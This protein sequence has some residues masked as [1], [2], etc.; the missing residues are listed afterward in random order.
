MNIKIGNLVSI[1]NHPYGLGSENVKISAIASM[2]PPI[3]V[4]S[5]MMNSVKEFD[6]ETGEEKPKQVKCIFYSHKS[7]KFESYWFNVN[8]LKL[9]EELILDDLREERNDIN[10]RG[11]FNTS[12]EVNLSSVGI[13]YPKSTILNELKRSFLN[14]QVVLKSCDHELGK[15]KTTFSKVDNK[16]SQKNNSHLDF[17]PP[18][19]TV[20]DVLLN[21]EKVSYNT[22]SGNQRKI[23]SYFL[24]KCKW[25]N[26]L[27][28]HFSE[29]FLPIDTVKLVPIAKSLKFV[30]EIISAKSFIRQNFSGHIVLESGIIIEHTYIQPI[31]LIFNH[32][33]YKVKYYDFFKNKFSEI[34]L[35]EI[36]LNEE[37]VE[38]SDFIVE[39]I[40]EYKVQLQDFS[41]IKDYVFNIDTYYRITYKD[42]Q[43]KITRRVIYVKEFI[44]DKV[45]IADC[46]LRDGEERH[47][48]LKDGSILKIEI[49]DSNI[50]R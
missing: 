16:S 43:D 31:E 21:D 38:L 12:S 29:G 24:L 8:H 34:D 25:Y 17:L 3:M 19:L 20:I 40:P 23:V 42:L 7:H 30:S 2:T 36:S 9:I 50:F 46:L 1:K 44:K 6:S 15:V 28:G 10:K 18:V 5:E 47:F 37:I 49:L 32:Y 45:I 22:K 11:E 27:S 14:R 4:V 39:K 26:P 41:S 48:R 35:L 33:Y 13:Q